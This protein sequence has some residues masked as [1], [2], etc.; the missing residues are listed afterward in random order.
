MGLDPFDPSVGLFGQTPSTWPSPDAIVDLRRDGQ[1][2]PHPHYARHVTV[3]VGPGAGKQQV[4]A[5]V[6]NGKVLSPY[7]RSKPS[8][9]PASNPGSSD[10]MPEGGTN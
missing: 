5:H 2:A 8:M 7:F 3:E 6:R 9:A 1:S 4:K 10:A